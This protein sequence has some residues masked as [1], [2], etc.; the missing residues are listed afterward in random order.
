MAKFLP[1]RPRYARE[2]ALYP[3]F[4]L[5]CF[6]AA[7]VMRLL[8]A[9]L[10]SSIILPAAMLLILLG[11]SLIFLRLRGEGYTRA[12]RLRRPHSR[13]WP[14]ILS[15][16]FVL[17][18]GTLLLSLLFGG[19]TTLGNTAVS[20]E[21]ASPRSLLQGLAGVPL[22]AILPALFEELFFRGILCTELD[23]RGALRAVLLGSLLFSLLHFDLANLPAYFFAG[24]LLTLLVYA[25]D[26]LIA[27]MLVHA[28]YSV[29]LLFAQPYLNALYGFTGNAELFLFLLI[30][31]FLTALLLLCLFCA[32]EYHARDQASVKPPRRDIPRDVQI[33]T[34]LDALCEV[35]VL[36]C[37]ALSVVGLILL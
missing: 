6:G 16:F 37:F 15:A 18:T 28:L 23:R 8:A 7:F 4:L 10:P 30:L 32:K 3:P 33:Y 5:F 1:P 25:T 22:M 21:S 20:F 17:L 29:T 26:S 13:H 34:L 14:L 12:M 24:A 31:L 36:L 11:T 19:T 9:R 35:P 27:A 2:R